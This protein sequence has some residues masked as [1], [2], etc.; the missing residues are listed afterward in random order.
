MNKHFPGGSGE[1]EDGWVKE[2][3]HGSTSKSS[4]I[5]RTIM[6]MSRAESETVCRIP[7]SKETKE[8]LPFQRKEEGLDSQLLV[9]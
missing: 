2:G 8:K 1:V 4:A 6:V 5:R 9:L 3:K 7:H